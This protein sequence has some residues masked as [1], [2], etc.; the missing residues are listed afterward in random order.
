MLRLP[1]L[2]KTDETRFRGCGGMG[3]EGGGQ[4]SHR[5]NE[6]GVPVLCFLH[7]ARQCLWWLPPWPLCLM[8]ATYTV[9]IRN[10]CQ[11][12]CVALYEYISLGHES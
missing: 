8:M 5:R 11:I 4:Q 3:E 12:E 6:Q 7:D 9:T 2:P 1:E 10:D